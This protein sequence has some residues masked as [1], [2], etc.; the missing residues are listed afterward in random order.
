MVV[1][2]EVAAR[3]SMPALAVQGVEVGL[4]PMKPPPTMPLPAT[5]MGGRGVGVEVGGRGGKRG[6]GL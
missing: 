5:P 6:R 3:K 4:P 1:K 2:K